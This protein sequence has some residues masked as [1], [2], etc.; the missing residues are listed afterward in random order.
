[1]SSATPQT[2]PLLVMKFGGTSVG[3]AERIRR[4]AEIIR[5]GLDERQLVIVTSAVAGVTDKLVQ[6]AVAASRGLEEEWRTIAEELAHQHR[7]MVG[8]LLPAAE[9]PALLHRVEQ[10]IAQVEKLCA[11]FSL[12]RETTPRAM[13]VLAS[14]GEVL[15]ADLLAA[16]LQANGS[17]A[18]PL[19]A[20]H[21]IITDDKFGNATPLLDETTD[22]VRQQL[23]PLLAQGLIPVVTGFRAATPEGAVT[24]LGR[25]G[26]DYS[27]TILGAALDAAEVWIWTDV[28]GVM[29]ADPRAVP[30]AHLLSEVA[31]GEILELSFFGAKVLQ[32]QAIRPVMSKQIPLHIKN[33]MNPG[34]QGTRICQ[35]V[36][37]S[38]PG[39]R[40][41]TSVSQA[42]MLT[43]N[44]KHTLSFPQL[45]SRL[46]GAL[47]QEK[48]AT[49]IVTQSSAEN[50]ISFAIHSLDEARIRERLEKLFE[51]ERLHGYMEPLEVLSNVGVV[52]AVGEN[53]KGTPG[54]AGRL[55]GA[56]GRRGINV[57]A[58]AQGSS[59]LSIS[60]AVRSADVDEAVRAVH[61]EFRP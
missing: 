15:A 23:F 27:A 60:F 24:T 13:D 56:L 59:E 42:S 31:Y 33:T 28:D 21:L 16:V 40:A 54:I 11:G 12:V 52:V 43:V 39:V 58:I 55:F 41:I 49:L 51:L 46:F 36:S 2:R 44:G 4:V 6:A 7:A 34:G 26:S 3:S 32:P 35:S 29:T 19:D 53:M 22:R 17:Q 10:E 48:V 37:N 5:G 25:G 18:V 30:E 1:M 50:V 38:R 8:T 61:A 14:T 57:I 20:A 45:A 9:Q 47:E